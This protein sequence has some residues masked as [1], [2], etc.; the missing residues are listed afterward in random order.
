[1]NLRVLRE[2]Q[3]DTFE[4]GNKLRRI[5]LEM[6]I[7]KTRDSYKKITIQQKELK[8][9]NKFCWGLIRALEKE[10]ENEKLR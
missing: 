6:N 9:K 1:M 10:K 3:R 8:D 4:K 5:P 7:R 2:M